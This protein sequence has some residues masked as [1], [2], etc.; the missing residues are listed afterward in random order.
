MILKTYYSQFLQLWEERDLVVRLDRDRPEANGGEGVLS[1]SNAIAPS[2]VLRLFVSGDN[3][4]TER[5]LE[6][7]HN[8]LEQG[9]C[10]PYTLKVIDVLKHPEQA[11]LNQVSATPTLLRVLP[12]PVKRIVGNLEDLERVLQIITMS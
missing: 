11:E 6:K 9:L 12:Q 4:A 1:A 7:V 8:L 2:Y 5:A 10:A 3:A